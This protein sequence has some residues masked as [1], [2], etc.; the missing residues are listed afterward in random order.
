ME[1]TPL[2]TGM[3]T[4]L[5]PQVPGVGILVT[6]LAQDAEEEPER[7]PQ[8]RA[9]FAR[10]LSHALHVLVTLEFLGPQPRHDKRR[11][12]HV[13]GPCAAKNADP[14][15]NRV[16][17]NGRHQHHEKGRSQTEDLP[18][19]KRNGFRHF[20]SR[21]ISLSRAH[22]R[23]PPNTEAGRD[24]APVWSCQGSAAASAVPVT[25]AR[26][27]I[28]FAARLRSCADPIRDAHPRALTAS[29]PATGRATRR[30]SNCS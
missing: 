14:D 30:R 24:V 25:R 16:D 17:E 23:A 6:Q 21:G 11:L 2:I 13:R 19:R 20:C 26:P 12:A 3:L 7:S 9:R 18:R 22:G 27:V 5:R 8:A 28:S 29:A 10:V 4:A 15:A 1:S